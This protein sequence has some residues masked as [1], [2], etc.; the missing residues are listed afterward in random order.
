[1][2]SDERGRWFRIYARQVREHA[3]FRDL[4]GVELGAWTALRSEAE[5]R[6]RAIIADRDEAVLILKRRRIARPASVLDRLLSLRLFD[7]SSDGS[8]IVH[9]REDHDRG[10]LPTDQQN[11]RRD[12]RRAAAA[13]DCRWCRVER[14]DRSSGEHGAWV[15]RTVDV[16]DH[17]DS[18]Q[19]VECGL[20]Q[21][22]APAHSQQPQ[23]QPTD[24]TPVGLPSEDDSATAACRLFLN[25][26]QWL[27]N[28][29]YVAAWDELDRRY[30][31]A[32][33]HA[34][35]QPA[36]QECRAENPKVKPWDLLRATELRCAI[37]ARAEERQREVA[38]AEASRREAEAQRLKAEA[39][40]EEER[41]RASLIRRAI[42]LWL[43]RRPDD[44]VPVDFE[45]LRTWLDEN[46]SAA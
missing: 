41:E 16:D 5:L 29:E 17:V 27:G 6:D 31:A 26:G 22:A 9:D 38:Q 44:P 21:Q 43:K 23:T 46:E 45:T 28:R 1:M 4:S 2:S 33:V 10:L 30:S 40:S 36:Y 15:D 37:R 19:D 24:A 18:P 20:P 25:G 42:G 32:W 3:K 34:E 12:H 8:I 35:L 7:L 39:A 11:H 14:W 13:D